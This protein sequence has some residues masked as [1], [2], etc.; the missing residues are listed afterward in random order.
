MVVRA[1]HRKKVW[2]SSTRFT[3]GFTTDGCS[4]S[5]RHMNRPINHLSTISYESLVPFSYLDG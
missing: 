2:G 1:G 5:E 3:R 4:A